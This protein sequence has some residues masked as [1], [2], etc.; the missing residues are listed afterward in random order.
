MSNQLY[1]K[2]K[3][4]WDIIKIADIP[5]SNYSWKVGNRKK[6]INLLKDKKVK[7]RKRDAKGRFIKEE[8]INKG[9]LT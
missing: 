3:S 7:L 6:L 9:E 4:N 8:Q 2:V 5:K 1:Q